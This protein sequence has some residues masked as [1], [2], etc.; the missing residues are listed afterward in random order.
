MEEAGLRFPEITTPSPKS[1]SCLNPA[2]IAA[3]S[4][5]FSKEKKK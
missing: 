4:E 1:I 2:G 3:W 5:T